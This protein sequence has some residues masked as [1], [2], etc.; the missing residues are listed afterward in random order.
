[1]PAMPRRER[2]YPQAMRV[3]STNFPDGFKQ[4]DGKCFI[5]LSDVRRL[6][7]R[8]CQLFA[9]YQR[10]LKCQKKNS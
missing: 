8:Y 4:I 5:P 6:E 9:R 10:R 1:M 3:V 2:K 7:K